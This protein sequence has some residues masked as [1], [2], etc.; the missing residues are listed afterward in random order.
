[1]ISKNKLKYFTS[2]HKK[3]HR[4]EE[5]VFIVE[6]DKIVE[7]LLCSNYSIHSIVALPTW[8]HS[9]SLLANSF[10]F[11]EADEHEISKISL[12][13]SP[14][15]VW[16][17]VK[18]KKSETAKIQSDS[19]LIIAL[20][21]IQDPGNLGT[22]IRLADWFGIPQILCSHSCVDAYNPKVVQASMGSIFRV[23][24]LY[25]DLVKTLQE[26]NNTPIFAADLQGKNVYT[27]NLPQHGVLIMGNE[28]NG[29]S[30]EVMEHVTNKIHIPTYNDSGKH[31]ESL[32]V[33]IATAILCSEFK[34]RN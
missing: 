8:K 32:N 13:Q 12:L 7:E 28:G 17:L 10:E 2:F 9:H 30:S 27:A 6:G 4:D 19:K 3:K 14:Q 15:N 1:M 16:A 21:S 25:C 5:N 34:R 29:I 22:I 23:E 11:Y 18:Y 33:A 31:P 20:D 24:I 26:L